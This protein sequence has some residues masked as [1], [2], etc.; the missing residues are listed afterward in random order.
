MNQDVAG[1]RV[2]SKIDLFINRVEKHI[3]VTMVHA[4]YYEYSYGFLV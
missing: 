2:E 3:F 4:Y 1:G